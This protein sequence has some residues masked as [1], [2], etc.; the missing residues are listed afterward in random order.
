MT[1]V[2]LSALRLKV[3]V[4]GPDHAPTLVLIH[5]LGLDLRLWDA[6]LPHLSSLRVIRLDLRGHGGSDSPAPPYTI[7][8]LVRDIDGVMTH[9]AVRDAVILGAGESGLIAQVLAAKR[10]DL[11]RALVL[12]GTSTRFANPATWEGHLVR[13]RAEGPDLDAELAALLGPRWQHSPAAPAIRTMLDHTRREGWEGFATAVAT[14]DL[15]QPTATLRLPT[16]VLIGTD[17]RK[18]PPDLQRETADLIND[19]TLHMIRSGSHLS[20]L[21]HPQAFADLLLAFLHRI[22]HG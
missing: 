20:M 14:A 3:Q 16:L 8:G 5:G 15:Y 7:G 4:T 21:T 11:A 2:W 12:T 13:L 1:L 9:L 10:L 18:V 6:L 17:D 19:A 22:T